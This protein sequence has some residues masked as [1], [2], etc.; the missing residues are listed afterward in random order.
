MSA[1]ALPKIIPVK[2]HSTDLQ[3]HIS[4]WSRRRFLQTGLAA[5]AL[6]YSLPGK[7]LGG[8][9]RVPPSERIALAAIGVGG[10]GT[11]LLRTALALPQAQVLA[12]CDVN[13]NQRQKAKNLVDRHYD[14]H[15]CRTYHDFRQ[16]LQRQDIDAVLIATPDHWHVPIAVAAMEHGKD[17]YM[18]KPMSRSVQ[19]DQILRSVVHRTGRI[20]QFGTQQRSMHQFR[21]ACELVRNGLLGKLFAIQVWAPASRPGGSTE[22]TDPPLELD[23]NFWLGPA[24]WAPY[25]PD[26][27][28]TVFHRKTWWFIRDYTLGWIS[29]WGIHPIDI[30]YWGA[31]PWMTGPIEVEGT[32]LFPVRGACDTA[33]TWNVTFRFASGLRLHFLGVPTPSK[34][35]TEARPTP[36][37]RERFKQTTTHGTAFEGSEGWVCV[38]RIRINA[39][40]EELLR[41]SPSKNLRIR[42]PQ[43]RNHILNF[44]QAVRTR[45]SPIAPIDQAVQSDLL[46]QIA[47]IAIRLGRKLRWDPQTEQ[48]LNDP[49]ANRRLHAPPWR[50]PWHLPVEKVSSTS[51]SRA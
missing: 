45:K 29:G 25:T 19:E 47:E 28:S 18:E 33:V 16:L 3:E 41:L 36:P 5:C 35:S 23:Y 11:Q 46:C 30:A 40:S 1:P 7:L 24:P 17:V 37:F 26:R 8:S 21:L 48:F 15:D 32:G 34:E 27:C 31:H 44:L 14:N 10:Q 39:S 12:V 22:P 42:L 4:R 38:D 43:S 2:I 9:D 13:R 50:S 20:F 51:C 6:P 49:E